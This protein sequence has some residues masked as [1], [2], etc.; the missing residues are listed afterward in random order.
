LTEH[1]HV[2]AEYRAGKV[3]VLGFLLGA[4]MKATGGSVSP[5]QAREALLKHL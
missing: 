2:V 1:A 4:V 3:A 5:A